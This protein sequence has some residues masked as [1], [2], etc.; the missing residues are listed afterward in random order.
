MGVETRYLPISEL[1][2]AYESLDRINFS[3]YFDFLKK[4]GLSHEEIN[5]DNYLILQLWIN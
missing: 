5:A 2:K 4:Q 3:N 1:S